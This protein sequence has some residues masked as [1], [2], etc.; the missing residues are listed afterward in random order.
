[1]FHL[2]PALIGLY[3]VWRFIPMLPVGIFWKWLIAISIMLV[4]QYHLINRLFLGGMAPEAPFMVLVFGGWLFGAFIL[5][6][7]FLLLIDCLAL[8]FWITHKTGLLTTQIALGYRWR[9]CLAIVAFVLSAVGVWQA[10]RIPD[11]RKVHITV[12]RLPAAL[13]GLR[14]VQL[15]DLHAS[16]LLQAPWIHA[17]VEKTNA[18]NPDLIVITG[19]SVDGSTINRKPDVAPLATLKAR[20]G[21][22]AVTG[23]HEYY[24]NYLNWM[25]ALKKLGL[26]ILSNEHVL[27]TDRNA[28]L[29]LAG[30]T[31]RV[32]TH[33][34]LPA[35][36]I[37][38][39]LLGAPQNLPIILIVH[40]PKGASDYAHAGVDL[41]LSGH[42]HGGQILGMHW[43]AQMF[44]D[45]YVSGLYRV[46]PM[47]LYISNG[48]GLWSGFPLRLGQSSEITEI[49]LHAPVT[50]PS[51]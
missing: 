15:S 38:K 48:T 41:Q 11:V 28:T 20:L 3:V 46:G 35:P 29:V 51:N 19:D 25:N 7:V 2:F 30:V 33:F 32:A 1:M 9:V 37:N 50:S 10:I 21:V 8:F 47:Q 27:I 31:D 4:S 22:F 5:L 13:D 45:G 6:T 24:S 23:N 42:T 16:R 44:N 43:T 36:D 40:Q 12:D 34:G 17:V 49:T 39:A 18:L 14:L 26:T